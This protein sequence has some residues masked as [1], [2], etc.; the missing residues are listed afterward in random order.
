MSIVCGNPS[1]QG[2]FFED[3]AAL[4]FMHLESDIER[5]KSAEPFLVVTLLPIL[6]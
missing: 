4:L 6:A 5:P 2:H 1:Q 3:L